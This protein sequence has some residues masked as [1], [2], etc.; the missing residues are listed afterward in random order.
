MKNRMN[1]HM[2]KRTSNTSLAIAIA[3]SQ[4]LTSQ[5]A[6]AESVHE[7]GYWESAPPAEKKEIDIAIN[8]IETSRNN[9]NTLLDRTATALPADTGWIGYNLANPC[10]SGCD[11][12]NTPN[13]TDQYVAGYMTLALNNMGAPV[14]PANGDSVIKMKGYPGTVTATGTFGGSPLNFS[15]SA[16]YFFPDS[17]GAFS[18][19]E[20]LVGYMSTNDSIIPG[21]YNRA[22]SA[23]GNMGIGYGS[24]SMLIGLATPLTQ[25]TEQLRLGQVYS[26]FGRSNLGSNV[27]IGVSFA[28]ASWEGSWSGT[29]GQHNG[30]GA[31]GTITGNTMTS[32]NV[33]GYGENNVNGHVTGGKIDGTFIGTFAATDAS[34]TAIIGKEV[35]TVQ[36][37]TPTFI[38]TT[39]PGPFGPQP[40]SVPGPSIITTVTKGDI[41]QAT[42]G[43]SVC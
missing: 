8:D 24:G 3:L 32:T 43:C 39:M 2:S 35:L 16:E 36:Q 25:M 40:I 27:N 42:G 20:S 28:N 23:Q 37:V 26:Y 1:K 5:L 11:N 4:L 9:M 22:F 21:D 13:K 33:T 12:I 17:Q 15:D 7:W 31:G 38:T 10:Y 19:G 41:F 18:T 34:N 6:N 30:F 29:R 14:A